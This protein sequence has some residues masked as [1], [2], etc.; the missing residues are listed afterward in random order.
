MLGLGWGLR[1]DSAGLVLLGLG[2]VL[3]IGA[4]GGT[5]RRLGAWGLPLLSVAI[6]TTALLLREGIAIGSIVEMLILLMSFG[7]MVAYGARVAGG[8]IVVGICGLWLTAPL[9]GLSH[10][11]SDRLRQGLIEVHAGMVG[12]SLMTPDAPWSHRPRAYRMM[13]LGQDVPYRL[14]TSIWQPIALHTGVALGCFSFS[15][16]TKRGTRDPS[17]SSRDPLLGSVDQSMGSFDREADDSSAPRPP[18]S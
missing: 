2:V 17:K 3:L 4:H 1:L 12:S 13:S 9:W 7:W 14:P 16:S 8:P 18:G 6:V 11:A 10:V 15:R 5:E